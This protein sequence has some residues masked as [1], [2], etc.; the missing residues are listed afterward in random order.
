VGSDTG[1][2]ATEAKDAATANGALLIG[3]L[4]TTSQLS[5]EVIG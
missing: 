4:D 2:A 1:V 3:A 5:R